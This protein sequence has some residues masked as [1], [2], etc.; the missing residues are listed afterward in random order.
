[1]NLAQQI[2]LPT[3]LTTQNKMSV[4]KEQGIYATI[5]TD[6][7]NIVLELEY[8]KTPMTVANFV[9][10]AE[11]KMENTAKGAGLP[12]YDGLKFHRV[13]TK[14]N[15]DPQ[16]F[17]V[18]GGCPNGDGRGGPGYRFGDE[19]D[20]SLRHDEPG[21]LSMANAGPGTNGSQFFITHVATPW[22]D[23]KHTV[24]GKVVE[25]MDIVN[26]IQ[27]NDLIESLE[28]EAIGDT[29]KAFNAKAVFEEFKCDS[30]TVSPYMGEDSVSPFLS[31][32]DKMVFL[33]C[34]TSNSGSNDFEKQKIG[35]DYLYEVVL[36]K[37][38]KWGSTDNLG[39]VVGATHPNEL[40]S[41]R[42]KSPNSYFLIPGVGVQGGSADDVINANGNGP[43]IINSSRGIIYAGGNEVKY[44]DFSR[45]AALELR[46]ELNESRN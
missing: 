44:A 28:I 12:Y 43:A 15:G 20:A 24:F 16:D 4:K 27:Q 21:I 3:L 6:K 29:A 8:K 38:M 32:K 13:I 18:Q 9:G 36:E 41:I 33:L 1:M 31:Y 30:I 14:G 23:G 37:S 26:S 10:L 46:N 42:E 17:M 35:S 5:E 11:G 45:L 19:C 7:G 2:I 40:K 22:L 25:G 34:L 39:F